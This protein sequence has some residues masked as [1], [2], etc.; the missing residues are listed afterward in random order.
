MRLCEVIQ[1]DKWTWT[2]KKSHEK[3]S[4]KMMND[5]EAQRVILLEDM[6]QQASQWIINEIDRQQYLRMENKRQEG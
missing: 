5:D 2:V 3:M 1:D 6:W 4:D